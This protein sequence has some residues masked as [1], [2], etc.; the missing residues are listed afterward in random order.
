MTALPADGNPMA[1]P[2][3]SPSS[4]NSLLSRPLFIGAHLDDIEIAAGGVAARSADTGGRPYFLVLSDSSYTRWDGRAGRHP[5]VAL[6]EG[7]EASSK[8][9]VDELDVRDFS[10]KD[11]EN[12]SSV[13]EVIESVIS[14]FKPTLIFTHWPFDTHKAHMNVALT[15]IAAARREPSVVFFEPFFP[16]GR[17]FQPFRPQLY[18]PVDSYIDVK[19]SALRA[20]KTEYNKFGED[21]VEAIEARARLRG[22]ESGSKFAEAFEVLRLGV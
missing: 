13:V 5:E 21:W 10:A 15:T 1:H 4:A 20:H 12:H 7:R 11:I 2:V 16:S 18:L 6:R 9:G 19:A 3:V 17:S 14:R 22:Y 8:L